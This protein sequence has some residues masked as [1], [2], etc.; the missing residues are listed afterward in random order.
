MEETFQD[1][2]QEIRCQNGH[3]LATIEYLNVNFETRARVDTI[4]AAQ[5]RYKITCLDC[6]SS[7]EHTFAG[8]MANFLMARDRLFENEVVYISY[9]IFVNCTLKNC[10]LIYKGGPVHA[11]RSSFQN[12]FVQVDVLLTD[13]ST[14]EKVAITLNEFKHFLPRPP[15]P[16]SGP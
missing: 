3:L 14:T 16:P 6:K 13:S 7:L 4:D 12:C 10:V 1:A 9:H 15:F 2:Q 11:I 5:N 8:T